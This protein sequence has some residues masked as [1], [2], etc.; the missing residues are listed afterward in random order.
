MRSERPRFASGIGAVLAFI[1][2]AVGLGNVWRFPYMVGA[3]GGG[4]FLLVYFAVLAV[5]GIPALMAEL[6]LGRATRRGPM[7]AFS[8]IGMPGGKAAGWL[9]FITVFMAVSYYTVI[10][11]WVLKY[12]L[13]S[14][15]GRLTAVD[16]DTFFNQI[17]EGF[18]GQFVATAAVILLASVVLLLG[19]RRGVETVSRYGMPLLFVLLLV[20]MGKTMTLEGAGEGFRFYLIPDFAKIDAGVVAAALGQVFFSLSL[21][22]TYLLTYASYLPDHV[23]LGRSA[24][25]VGLGETMAAVLAGFVIVP[26]AVALN[27]NLESGPPLTFITAPTIFATMSGGAVFATLFFGLLFFAAFLSDVA[28]FEVLIASAND[29][30]GWS[31]RKAITVFGVL[32]L[33]LGTVSMV[34]L[35]FML[36]SDLIWG[37]T[38]QPLGSAVTLIG[39]AWVVGLGKTM[40]EV[41]KSS[42]PSRGQTLWFYWIKYVVPAGIIIILAL[43]VKDMFKTFF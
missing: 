7:G 27:L 23:K 40:E 17:L 29:S 26:A 24:I 18:G 20:L 6:T 31:R 1:G 35:D 37:S 42:P 8:T 10:V 13:A 39:L 5:F 41:R 32:E 16:A 21:G 33:A 25:A 2:V 28:A 38:M 22:G 43:G 14:I 12:L 34:S 19:I 36:K 4:A 9:L 11:G 15:T 3:F 30:F